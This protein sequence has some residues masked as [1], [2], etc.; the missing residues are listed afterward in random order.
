MKVLLTGGAGFIGSHVADS[1]LAKGYEVVV[2]DDL[3]TGRRENI[4]KGAS[5]YKADITKDDIAGI[6]K[7]EG[8][9]CVV[10]HA[11]QASVR[12]SVED[13]IYD[14]HVNVFGTLKVLEA[15]GDA[16]KF[17][18]SSTGGAI[19]G[20]P[21]LLPAGEAHEAKPLSPYGVSKYIGEKYI[22]TYSAL[23][24][25]K[26]VSLRYGNV[27][28]PRQDPNGEAGVVAIFA[29]RL[30]AGKDLV[31]FGDGEQTRDFVYV[32]DVARANVLSLEKEVSGVFNIGS[33]RETSVNDVARIMLRMSGSR[34]KAVRASPIPGEV[35]RIFL[36]CSKAG[37]ELGWKA[38]VGLE[39]GIRRTLEHLKE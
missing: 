33:G 1:F 16:D 30:L 35:R 39:E 19:Y 27:Y 20:D 31:I 34:V 26:Y 7:E 10:H 14:A 23:H 15:C 22:E 21:A 4:P 5:F 9:G 37:K 29:G 32:G 28:G 11:A 36:D 25:L 13:P 18:Y 17:I 38:E 2:V 12:R 6:A 24:G 3:S 8:I